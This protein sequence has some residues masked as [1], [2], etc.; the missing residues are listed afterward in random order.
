MKFDFRKAILNFVYAFVLVTILTFASS[1]VAAL[2]F[3]LPSYKDL[4]ISPFQDP[5]FLKMVPYRIL[6]NLLCWIFFSFLYLKAKKNE[7]KF[8]SLKEASYLGLLWLV[9]AMIADFISFVLIDSPM[10][11]TPHQFYVENQPWITIL[12]FIVLIA[13]LIA[14]GLLG[15]K[16]NNDNEATSLSR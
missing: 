2:L 15:L 3:K 1:A 13:P 8:I 5:S 16:R 7:V 10:S 12:Y 4:G 11:F 14:F 9:L 6:I